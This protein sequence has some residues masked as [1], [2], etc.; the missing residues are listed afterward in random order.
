VSKDFGFIGDKSDWIGF[1]GG[2]LGSS[3]TIL[4]IFIQLEYSR[5][6][7]LEIEKKEKIAS[8][9][10]ELKCQI[11]QINDFLFNEYIFKLYNVEI[12]Y[13]YLKNNVLS[14]SRFEIL[15]DLIQKTEN[16]I[17]L[18]YGDSIRKRKYFLTIEEGNYFTF[19]ISLKSILGSN[20]LEKKYD[21]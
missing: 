16:F 11:E 5:K 8:K 20:S 15:E 4:G 21:L 19:L 14:D 2:L 3:L 13:N 7:K 1:S 6:E 18:E 17:S 10:R 9:N 12:H